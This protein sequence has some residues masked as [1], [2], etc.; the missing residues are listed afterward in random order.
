M[1]SL[2]FS[3]G[4]LSFIPLLLIHTRLIHE[5]WFNVVTSALIFAVFN[6]RLDPFIH[7]L[8]AIQCVT[9]IY[10]LRTNFRGNARNL[11]NDRPLWRDFELSR[12]LHTDIGSAA[13]RWLA[14]PHLV[15]RKCKW[16]WTLLKEKLRT[17]LTDVNEFRRKFF[18][19]LCDDIIQQFLSLWSIDD[20]RVN[21]TR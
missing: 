6:P 9:K 17:G 14:D 18:A 11:A 5:S 1:N 20:V 7:S 8:I 3:L 21:R 19:L 4:Y 13:A 16:G 15:A 12:W 2:I 10:I